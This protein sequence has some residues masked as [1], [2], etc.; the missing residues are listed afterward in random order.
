MSSAREMRRRIKSV[1]SLAQ[2]TKALETVSASKV[3]K[4]I[5]AVEM[6]RPYAEKAWKVLVHLARQPG[7]TTLHPLLAERK[8]I[9]KILVVMVSSDQGL[10]GS[11]NI[12]ILRKTIETFENYSSLVDYLAIGKKGRDLLV[13]R[14]K[15]VIAE[16]SNLP[17]HIE[18]HDVSAIG[19]LVVDDF[20]NGKYDQIFL[21]YTDYL[22]M[23]RQETIVRKLLPLEVTYSESRVKNFNVTHHKTNAVFTYEPDSEEILGQIVTRFTAIQIYQAILTS[24]AS[25]HAARMIAMRNATDNARDL[26]NDLQLEYNKIRQQSITNDILDIASGANALTAV[27][28]GPERYGE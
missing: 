3:K 28:N 20:I 22:S 16:F 12:N 26:S 13:R 2:I 5:Q 9:N 10:A 25:E 27:Q 7:H 11:Y 14:R 15:N 21:A 8:T 19:R 23:T 1:K 17:Q 4:A 6:T 24:K 18:F